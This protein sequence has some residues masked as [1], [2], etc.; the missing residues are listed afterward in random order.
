MNTSVSKKTIL[1]IEDEESLRNALCDKITREGFLTL[2]AK[3]GEQGLEIALAK[4]PDLI[5][6]DILMPI[7]DGLT[8]LKKLGED[9][10]GREAKVI[11]LTN[12]S[13]T[14]NVAVAAE[15]GSRDYLV[16]SYW[17]IEDVVAKVKEKLKA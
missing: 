6:L 15:H 17:K 12:L 14:E 5:L 1:I 2:E 16:K 4:H 13:D 7:M 3:N 10:W 11:M 9:E 8:V